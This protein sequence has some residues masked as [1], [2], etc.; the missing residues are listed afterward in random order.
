MATST[1]AVEAAVSSQD[2]YN[3]CVMTSTVYASPQPS[4]AVSA[5]QMAEQDVQR[6]VPMQFA[7]V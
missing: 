6:C 3:D 2:N 4:T 1:S 7:I 5:V